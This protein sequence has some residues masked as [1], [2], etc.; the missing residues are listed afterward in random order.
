MDR[1]VE[2][3]VIEEFLMQ[4]GPTHCRAAFAA[5]TTTGFSLRQ[6]ADRIAAI[7]V[8]KPELSR[9]ML[10]RLMWRSLRRASR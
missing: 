4:R 8:K 7:Q 6:E 5:P 3:A 2:L 10:K 1:A 9:T